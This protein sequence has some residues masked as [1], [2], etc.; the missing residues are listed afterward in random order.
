M[1]NNFFKFDPF[2]RYIKLLKEDVKVPTKKHPTDAGW[3]VYLPERLTLEPGQFKLV[4]LGFAIQCK[5]GEYLTISARSSSA[6]LGIHV[7]TAVSD[8]GYTGELH[9]FLHNFSTETRIFE[10]NERVF[11]LIFINLTPNFPIE[12]SSELPITSPRGVDG[13]GS[14]GKN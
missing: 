13:F 10:K 5:P 3:D 1:D 11:Q 2:K 9:F 14:T 4:R 8:A 12:V 6:V 7:P